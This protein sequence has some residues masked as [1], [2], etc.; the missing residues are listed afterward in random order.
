MYLPKHF[1]ERDPERL[2]SFIE[3]CPLGSLVTATESG[4]DANHIPFLF[5][6]TGSATGTLHGHIA[7]ANPLWRE[8]VRDATVLVIFQGPDSFISP[9][10]Y[11]SKREN[12]RVVP[13]WNYAVVHVHGVLRCVDD[14]VWVRSHVEA[15]TR[16]HEGKRDAPWAVADAPADFI[17]KMVAA[18]VGIEISITRL[19]GKWKV[20]QNRSISDRV[21]VVEGLEREAVPSGTSIAALIRQ[22][23]DGGE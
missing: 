3:R 22:T 12:A 4:L 20:S 23:L 17:E 11:P 5:A 14:P 19:V 10:W 21:G 2:R 18:V 16:E 1:E 9:S 8:V 13:T 15:L 6:D 7:R